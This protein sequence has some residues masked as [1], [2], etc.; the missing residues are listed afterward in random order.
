MKIQH[1]L[2]NTLIL[3]VIL[4]LSACLQNDLDSNNGNDEIETPEEQ[5]DES[6][7]AA[8]NIQ[9]NNSNG[10]SASAS[11]DQPDTSSSNS[12]SS[13]S[14]I[15]TLVSSY[16]D[17]SVDITSPSSDDITYKGLTVNFSSS[18]SG[19]S[20]EVTY[21]WDFDGDGLEDSDEAN[22]DYEFNQIG[23]YDVQLTVSD[24]EVGSQSTTVE[25]KVLLSEPIETGYYHS[26]ALLENGSV[27]CWGSNEYGQLGTGDNEDR[28]IPT[29]VQGI[30]GIS[31]I[32]VDI[33]VGQ[34]HS[35]AVLLG[36]NINCWGQNIQK[37]LGDGS[38]T[39]SNIPVEIDELVIDN[40]LTVDAGQVHTCALLEEGTIKCW[41]N[42]YNGKLGNGLTPS[43]SD[44]VNVIDIENAY[45]ISLGS[46]HTC[47]MIEA[48]SGE[49]NLRC[50]GLNS[51]G[52]LG[53]D[54]A[55]YSSQSLSP[56]EVLT[57]S[58][59]KFLDAGLSHTCA[60]VNDN[61]I[62]CWGWNNVGQLGHG[63]TTSYDLPQDVENITNAINL[64]AG[65]YNT[66]A[67]LE[68]GK[69]NC[70]GDNTY[71]KLGNG[72]QTSSTIPVEVSSIDNVLF[73]N[74]FY[75]HVCASSADSYY[76]W[77]SNKYGQ[78]GDSSSTASLSLV[79]L[80]LLD[81]S[82]T[83]IDT[84]RANR[85]KTCG[86][87]DNMTINCVGDGTYGQL[88]NNGA[89]IFQTPQSVLTI[90]AST[91]AL[92]A[93]NLATGNALHSCAIMT[94]GAVKCWGANY[95]GQLGNSINA[96][97]EGSPVDVTD[98]DGDD[99]NGEQTATDL[100]TGYAFS[101]A[102]LQDDSL[103][104]WGKNSSGQLGNETND[105]SY[106]P[107]LVSGVEGTT[108]DK[109]ASQIVAGT[110][111]ACVLLAD[112][113][114]K[115][116]GHNSSGQLGDAS[117]DSSNIPVQVDGIEGNT[118]ESSAVY[119]A[120]GDSHTCAIL[121][122][123]TVKCWGANHN[124]QL[125]NAS[126]TSSNTPV[127]ISGT[128]SNPYKVYASEHFTCLLSGDDNVNC[129]GD[130]D[131]GQLGNNDSTITK[132]ST[133]VAFLGLDS[134]DIAEIT[135]GSDHICFLFTNNELKCLGSNAK[136]QLGDQLSIDADYYEPV[137]IDIE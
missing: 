66:C 113:S 83:L 134:Y 43:S 89:S 121:E 62:K 51:S 95:Y 96:I 56:I 115:C 135:L 84:I 10:E 73:V 24:A 70:W 103:K 1:L 101:C 53:N 110:A 48:N 33:A 49:S 127:L 104:C 126:L 63:D 6:T 125:G 19:G 107:V 44:P 77:G 36:G 41:G 122:N 20:G 94:N 72:T 22:P 123:D 52:E 68:T 61:S 54:G 118:E 132:S 25:M 16:D 75:Q 93:G 12:S 109:S 7:D 74:L 67:V 79:D 82:A 88:G 130:N 69:L 17:L 47:A 97:Y 38:S 5:T 120:S 32:A 78:I 31:K 117:N 55:Q 87:D 105:N 59:A 80:N 106:F 15:S 116:W 11:Q 26:C 102:I 124:G 85:D 37:Q 29:Q 60:I 133:P 28:N 23:V 50:W 34:Y 42:G 112:S 128:Y 76:C 136:G 2:S 137:E 46:G 9:D 40:A 98:I 8:D 35:C 81:A 39:N 27:K 90:D 4:S 86:I 100:A 99:L 58:D 65:T 92:S 13:T 114:V 129:W 108:V 111:H 64:G 18:V 131:F 119:L 71:G 3:L 21:S 45:H 57:I 91:P 30:D 14:S